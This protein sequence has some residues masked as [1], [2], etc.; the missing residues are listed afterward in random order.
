MTYTP[1]RTSTHR[2]KSAVYS[3]FKRVLAYTAAKT[4]FHYKD[5]KS[6]E[7]ILFLKGY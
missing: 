7:F 1:T 5:D 4:C 3:G 6:V 2:D